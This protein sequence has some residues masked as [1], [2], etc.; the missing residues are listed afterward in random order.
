MSTRHT[1]ITS[2]AW[3]HWL[4]RFAG[5]DDPDAFGQL[6]WSVGGSP[7]YG[8]VSYE[9]ASAVYQLLEE[10]QGPGMASAGAYTKVASLLK[11]P[12]ARKALELF[13][14]RDRIGSAPEKVRLKDADEGLRLAIELNHRGCQAYFQSLAAQLFQQRGDIAAARQRALTALTTFAA[15]SLEDRA[16]MGQML[17][18]AVNATSFSAMEGEF[19]AAR[20][21]LGLVEAY[22]DDV[23]EHYGVREAV[24]QL[25][26]VLG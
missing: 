22:G 18:A 14:I 13:R 11:D 3:P 5:S 15:L 16:Y 12:K 7:P 23:L 19:A 1:N 21:T 9:E 10:Y 24:T 2:L 20:Q 6:V 4:L 17:K 26:S 25:R 8:G